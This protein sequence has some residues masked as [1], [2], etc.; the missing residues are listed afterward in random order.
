MQGCGEGI[1]SVVV[2]RGYYRH[3]LGKRKMEK[4]IRAGR[5]VLGGHGSG[6]ASGF[7]GVIYAGKEKKA[8]PAKSKAGG[9]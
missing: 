7:K 5:E 2:R 9:R 1:P 6:V 8:W 4:T 3:V